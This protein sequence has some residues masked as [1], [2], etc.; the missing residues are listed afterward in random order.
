MLEMIIIDG[1]SKKKD[2]LQPQKSKGVRK[3]KQV[4]S[5]QRDGHFLTRKGHSKHRN[6]KRKV[7]PYFPRVEI[8]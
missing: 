4:E 8:M 1:T 5:P 2:Y 6:I 3:L 7:F